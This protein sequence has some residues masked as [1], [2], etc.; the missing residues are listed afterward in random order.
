LRELACFFFE[1]HLLQER[2]DA[3][4]DLVLRKLLGSG[5]KARAEQRDESEGQ[6]TGSKHF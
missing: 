4:L 2:V 3:T 6:T 5:N 1:R